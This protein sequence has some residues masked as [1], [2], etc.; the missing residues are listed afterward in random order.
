M[1]DTGSTSPQAVTA[2]I[3][4]I[5]DEILSG[6]TKDTNTG[7]ICEYLTQIGVEAREVRV[8]PDVT[9]MIVEAI[10]TLRGR[11]TY[12]FTTGGIGPTHDDITAD[13]VASAYGVGID[14]D[15]RAV[16]MLRR[17]YP[18]AELTPARL[19][20]ARIPHGADLIENA[21]S[22]APG[23]RIDNVFVMAGV[24]RVM[25]SMMD[26]IG[27]TLKTG[28]RIWSETVDTGMPEGRIAEPLGR[29]AQAHPDVQ[30]GSYPHY[31]GKGFNTQIVLRGR[32]AEKL[33][34]AKSDVV[35]AVEELA[36][37]E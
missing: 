23:F 33:Q 2:G 17:R 22:G 13:A 4:V 1:T 3:V 6:R 8:V 31:D 37:S 27:P 19:R 5:G 11:Y 18:D 12:V 24:P 10:D 25:Q 16:E 29:I 34:A 28:S 32:D 14:V 7:Y 20:M 30:I 36:Q 21:V 15:P 35:A 9:A 26:T